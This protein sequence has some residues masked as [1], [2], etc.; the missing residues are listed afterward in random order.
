MMQ[1]AT[2]MLHAACKRSSTQR[3]QS[4]LFLS[5]GVCRLCRWWAA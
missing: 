5:T 2:E 1:A 4:R 3:C